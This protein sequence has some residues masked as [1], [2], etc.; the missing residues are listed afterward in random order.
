MDGVK[1]LSLPTL[2][3]SR[4][5]RLAVEEPPVAAPDEVLVAV[6]PQDPL[7]DRNQPTVLSV[8]REMLQNEGARLENR[9]FSTVNT[10]SPHRL[11]PDAEGNFLYAPGTPEFAQVNAHVHATRTV[12][13]V[14]RLRGKAIPWRFGNPRRQRVA[15][16]VNSDRTGDS[17]TNFGPRNI[18]L[19]TYMSRSLGKEVRDGECAEAIAHEVGHDILEGLRPD[20]S[21]GDDETGAFAEA[22][23]DT[24]AI[25]YTMEFGSNCE[26]A[27]SQS[28]GN[29]RHQNLISKLFEEDGKSQ[30]L[31]ANP[32]ARSG[33]WLRSALNDS[34]YHPASEVKEYEVHEQSLPYTA[35][36]YATLADTYE[37]N[38][39]A[40]QA[41]TTALLNARD[42]LGKVWAR[43]LDY[44]P[45][46]NIHFSDGLAALVQADRELG[47][48]LE[49]LLTESFAS[50]GI[51]A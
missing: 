25:L 28:H 42:T 45:R 1:L 31:A 35:A 46:K 21:E 44:L 20:H 23:G 22:F 48:G 43:S 49:P 40:G 41:P 8:P 36:F 24:V 14:E 10:R 15:V 19:D 17:H 6:F 12:Q 4:G 30:R 26:R 27:L 47:T 3:P 50:K 2:P 13:M 9:W 33:Y 39:D 37:R 34:Q 38:R 16:H 51:R 18:K 7:V 29:L 5:H 11:E 32:N